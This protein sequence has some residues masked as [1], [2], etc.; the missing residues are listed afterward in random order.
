MHYIFL[1]LYRSVTDSVY[2]SEALKQ[3]AVCKFEID[4]CVPDWNHPSIIEKVATKTLPP[5]ITS[6]ADLQTKDFTL[7]KPSVPFKFKIAPNPFA[8]GSECIVYHASD[9]VNFRKI[10]LKKFKRVKPEYNSLDSYMMKLALRTTAEIYAQEFNI[11]KSKPNQTCSI[12]FTMLD[13][14][15]TKHDAFYIM[16][17]FLDEKVVKFNNNSGVVAE[18]IPQSDLMQAF[19][20]YSWVRSEKTLLICDLQGYK[21]ERQNKIILTD[22]AIHSKRRAGVYGPLDAGFDGVRIFFKTHVCSTIC[23]Q[24]KLTGQCI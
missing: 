19:S 7:E 12:A 13:I 15:Q 20:H 6:L 10:V 2:G 8:E 16:E 14:V 21:E 11:E 17:P 9:L 3:A 1:I 22:P 4:T 5:P 23:S 18:H 24:M